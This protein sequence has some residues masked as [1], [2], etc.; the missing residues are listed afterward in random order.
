MISFPDSLGALKIVRTA[1]EICPEVPVLVRTR[2]DTE[3]DTLQKAGATEIVPDSLEAALMLVSHLLLLLNVPI[4]RIVHKVANI[5]G[6]R[7][8]MLRNIFRK[9]DAAVLD[10]SHAFRE[11][12]QT[13]TLPEGAAG[14]GRSLAELRLPDSG[15]L[16]TAIRR[17]GIVGRQ[18]TADTVLKQEDVLVLYGTPESLERAETL[19]LSG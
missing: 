7:Y 10:E 3:L 2:D 5:R 12:L 18:P 19:L 13:L 17:Q 4:S 9:E 15:I 8:S 11:Q 6:H 16:I 14:V 1:K